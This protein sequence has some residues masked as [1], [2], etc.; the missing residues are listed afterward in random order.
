MLNVMLH[1]SRIS[2]ILVIHQKRLIDKCIDSNLLALRFSM[3]VPYYNVYIFV[4]IIIMLHEY[5]TILF[6]EYLFLLFCF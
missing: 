2:H 1:E 3:F 6:D 4:Y 5:I